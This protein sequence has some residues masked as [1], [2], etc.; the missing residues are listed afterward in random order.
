MNFLAHAYLS[1]NNPSILRGNLLGDFVKGELR[2][3][4][5]EE[6]RQG[7]T[8]HRFIDQFTD[9]HPAFQTARQRMRP[10]GIMGAGVFVDIIFD[11]MLAKHEAYF[12]EADLH[13]FSQA[14]YQALPFSHPHTPPRALVFFRAMQEHNWLY[15]YRFT[16]GTEKSLQGMCHRYP[17]LGNAQ[18]VVNLFHRH[19]DEMNEHFNTLFPALEAACLNYLH[20]YPTI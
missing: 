1:F 18:A 2:H 19:Y 13:A 14:V 8:L 9:Q 11:H 4:F 20:Q 10:A 16:E 6:E 12:S 5:T 15:R 3:A 17:R 7:L